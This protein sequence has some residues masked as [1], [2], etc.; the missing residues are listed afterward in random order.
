M[1]P[2]DAAAPAGPVRALEM[3]LWI[4]NSEE[5]AHWNVNTCSHNLR[6]AKRKD[7]RYSHEEQMA[8]AMKCPNP[9]IA[10]RLKRRLEVGV[11]AEEENEAYAKLDYLLDQMERQARPTGPGSPAARST[12]ADIAMAPM[13]N[14]IEVLARPEMIARVAPAQGGRLVAAHP[15]AARLSDGVLVREPGHQRSGETVSHNN[16]YARTSTRL[17]LALRGRDR[18]RLVEPG[19]LAR[20]GLEPHRGAEEIARRIHVLAARELRHHLRRAMAVTLAHDLH[21]CATLALIA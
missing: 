21:D 8:A 11:S 5:L 6:H 12:L 9:M 1:F 18:D 3:R 7:Q 14:R 17:G 20:A 15:G 2:N 13:V 10:L 4:Y 19:E 16:R